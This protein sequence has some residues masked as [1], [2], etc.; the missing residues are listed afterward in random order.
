MEK[1]IIKS[2]PKIVDK[3]VGN[4]I[5]E[6]IPNK[7]WSEAQIDAFVE[8]DL[9]GKL[10]KKDVIFQ[11]RTGIKEI[12]SFVPSKDSEAGTGEIDVMIFGCFGTQNVDM[13]IEDKIANVSV[14]TALAEGLIY[15]AGKNNKYMS[16]VVIGFNGHEVVL[17]VRVKDTW[18]DLYLNGERINGFIGPEILKLIYQYPDYNVFEFDVSIFTQKE[19]HKIL[20]NLRI[21]YRNI[22]G[23]LADNENARIDFTIAYVALKMITEKE[24]IEYQGSSYG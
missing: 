17:K 3:I 14:D 2:E 6:K 1:I 9:L 4:V 22:S 10:Y 24:N 5:F 13:I 15:A 8:K 21:I 16:R 18:Q 20:E 12:D 11:K 7:N 19:F 23:L